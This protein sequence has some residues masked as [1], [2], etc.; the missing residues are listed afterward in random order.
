MEEVAENII[1]A[2]EKELALEI[3]NYN[4]TVRLIFI[5]D[6]I[7]AGLI[8]FLSNNLMRTEFGRASLIF[9]FMMLVIITL[10]GILRKFGSN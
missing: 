6:F 4:W 10:M 8:L 3:K 1:E 2:K 7:I 9:G 5:L